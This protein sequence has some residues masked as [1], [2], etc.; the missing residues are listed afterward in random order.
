MDLTVDLVLFTY[1][2]NENKR[3]VPW[4][5]PS[6]AFQKPVFQGSLNLQFSKIENR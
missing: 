3:I 4:V 1:F 2:K 5:V 6:A